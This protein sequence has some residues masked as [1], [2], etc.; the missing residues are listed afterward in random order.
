[1]LIF[2]FTFVLSSCNSIRNGKPKSVRFYE[3]KRGDC[4]AD[5]PTCIV[6]DD[7]HCSCDE[8]YDGWLFFDTNGNDFY[9]ENFGGELLFDPNEYEE[10][11]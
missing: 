9:P 3:V 5:D 10:E 4:L 2:V 7:A 11:Q 1:M 8:S 6:A